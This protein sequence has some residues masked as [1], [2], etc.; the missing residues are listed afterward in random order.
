MG[1]IDENGIECHTDKD[2][3]DAFARHF[4]RAFSIS[5]NPNVDNN[6]WNTI[7][8]WYSNFFENSSQ[9]TY[10]LIT[11]TEYD[12]AISHIK[13]TAP[14]KDKIKAKILKSLSQEADNLILTQLNHCIATNKIPK[15]WKNGI[16]IPIP[17]NGVDNTH[18]EN[19]RPITLLP[20][21]SKVYEHIIKNRLQKL[22]GQHIVTFRDGRETT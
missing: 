17:K 20:V 22:I 11:D 8:N 12:E 19:Y 5:T 21:L 15:T 16:V 4:H 1:T 6:N 13:N 9:N 18:T 2:K 7:N 3:A 14:G 10:K